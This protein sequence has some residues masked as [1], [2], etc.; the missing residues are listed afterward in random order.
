MTGNKS[1]FQLVKFRKGETIFNEGEPGDCA[2]LIRSGVVKI[3]RMMNNTKLSITHLKAG[4]IMGEMA[5]IG[6]APRSASAEAAENCELV[7]IDQ[8][9]L[10]LA[11]DKTLP[12]IKA[13]L[14]QLIHRFRII[15]RQSAVK[16]SDK[17][18]LC[19]CSIVDSL[20]REPSESEDQQLFT[21]M[22]SRF[23]ITEHTFET[24]M[25][26]LQDQGLIRKVPSD[27]GSR[28]SLADECKSSPPPVLSFDDDDIYM[29][30]QEFAKLLK[31]TVQDVIARAGIGD[32]PPEIFYIS[33]E[34]A[35]IWAEDIGEDYFDDPLDDLI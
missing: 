15:D 22:R 18:M 5:V 13:M 17:I 19:A 14:N 12:V 21:M 6:V 10:N 30:I 26:K 35:A 34:R 7:R 24:I 1:E 28:I 31:T 27:K 20:H 29:H 11:L 8:K 32:I 16:E 9:S 3:Y 4:Q 2:Y 25:N 33:R 23:G